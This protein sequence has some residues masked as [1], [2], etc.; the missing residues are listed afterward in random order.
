MSYKYYL[1]ILR[2]GLYETFFEELVGGAMLPFVDEEVYGRSLLECSSFLASSA[3]P[4]KDVHG[5]GFLARLSGSTAEFLSMWT[6]IFLGPAPFTSTDDTLSFSLSPALPAWLFNDD[7]E[8]TFKLFS[9]IVVTYHNDGGGDL[10]RGVVS[11]YVVVA[12][13]G[14]EFLV[15]GSAVEGEVANRIRAVDVATIDAWFD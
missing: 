10:F 9:E 1:Q 7:G 12:K 6:L 11:R 4:S 2:G 13:D 15:E 3:F 5:R 14:E 8:V